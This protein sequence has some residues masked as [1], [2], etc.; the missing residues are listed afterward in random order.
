MF[1]RETRPIFCLLFIYLE[2]REKEGN[3]E[4]EIENKEYY[5]VS[6]SLSLMCQEPGGLISEGRERD[7]PTQAKRTNP[8][9][10]CFFVLFRP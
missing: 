1:S 7:T 2:R 5:W 3:G 6:F 8:L 4:R 10:S 9:F